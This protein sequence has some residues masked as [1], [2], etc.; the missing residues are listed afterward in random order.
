MKAIVTGISGQDGFYMTSKLLKDGFDVIGLTKSRTRA[1]GE[2]KN[3]TNSENLNIIEFDY[4]MER[5]F[6]EILNSFKPNLIFNFAAQATGKGMFDNPNIISRLNGGFVI[7][8]LESIR[9][10]DR[11]DEIVFCQASSSEMFGKVIDF[12]QIESSPFRPKSPYGAAKLYAHNMIAVYRSIYSVNCCSAILY[13]HESIRRSDSFVTK[14]IAKAAAKIKLGYQKSLV[15]GTLDAKRDWGYAPEYVEA[16]YLMATAPIL[17]D[18]IVS[19]G[20]LHS[21][22]DLCEFAFGFLDLD[23]RK[24]VQCDE[25]VSRAVESYN[26]LGNPDKAYRDLGWKSQ[27]TVNQIMIELVENE[28]R[29]LSN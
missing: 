10:S 18:Y 28:I 19:T 14:K 20:K 5:A 11:R 2:Y 13:N 26:L 21:V 8:I 27:K 1:L 7:D 22:R 23:Y 17:D 24:Y 16:I 12:P 25:K 9:Q 6:S 29:M 15:L 3:V 4:N